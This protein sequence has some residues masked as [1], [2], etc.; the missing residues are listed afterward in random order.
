MIDHGYAFWRKAHRAASTIIV[1]FALLHTVLTPILY[2]GWTP[3]SVW[4]LGTGIGLM[5]LG[6][7][8]L[9]HIGIEPCR[10]PTA[11][12]VRWANYVFVVFGGAAVVAVPELHA[13]VLVAAIAIQAAA[14]H[15]TLPGPVTSRGE[16]E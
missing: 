6:A 12:L 15:W 16:G 14:R 4:F 3:D 11:R 10:S 7:L 13:F 2:D 8:N 9:A 1:L 5:L